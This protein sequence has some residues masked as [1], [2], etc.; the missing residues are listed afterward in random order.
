[1]KRRKQGSKE[2]RKEESKLERKERCLGQTKKTNKT[3]Q[4]KKK[5]VTPLFVRKQIWTKVFTT[6]QTQLGVSFSDSFEYHVKHKQTRCQPFNEII[7]YHC[8]SGERK[9]A[10]KREQRKG[11]K[12]EKEK[13]GRQERR[14]KERK[15]PRKE[16]RK[17][18]LLGQK[19]NNS[20]TTLCYEADMDKSVH[21]NA[22]HSSVSVLVTALRNM[23]N[24][25]RLW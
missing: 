21:Q 18:R 13:K 25:T 20:H 10:S 6:R 12:E 9:E 7:D 24:M 15:N 4:N 8:K 19:N 16:A 1:M 5:P 22:K 3:K 2:G 11:K 14:K 23:S 17:K